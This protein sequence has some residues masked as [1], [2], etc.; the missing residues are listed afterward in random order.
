ML[1]QGGVS[2][3]TSN[4]STAAPAPA[5]ALADTSVSAVDDCSLGATSQRPLCGV[6]GRRA[7]EGQHR[8]ACTWRCYFTQRSTLCHA[9]VLWM[10]AHGHVRVCVQQRG[11]R[12]GAG[13]AS[14]GSTDEAGD[15]PG[16]QER[17]IQMGIRDTDGHSIDAAGSAMQQTTTGRPRR[18]KHAKAKLDPSVEHEKPQLGS[19][20]RR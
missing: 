8:I 5:P 14:L 19:G 11:L 17:L 2:R 7:A 12:R 6:T 20:N 4:G 16:V 13:T 15:V 10:R 9:P 3:A 18:K 1:C